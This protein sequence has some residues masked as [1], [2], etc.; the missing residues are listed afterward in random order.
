MTTPGKTI[1]LLTAALIAACGGSSVV[2]NSFDDGTGGST[3]S[4][5]SSSTSSSSSS[6][7]TG[8][9]NFGSCSEPGVC[10][11]HAPGCCGVCGKPTLGQ[12]DAINQSAT[13]AHYDATCDDPAGPCPGCASQPNPD[14]FAY[15]DL[16]KKQCVGAD[17][18]THPLNTCKQPSDC[19]LRYGL[20]CCECGS[21]GLGLTAV[22]VDYSPVAEL[23]CAGDVGCLECQ[24]TYPQDVMADCVGGKCV[25]AYLNP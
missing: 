24:P 4:S 7:S 23:V 21:E 5:S 3:T 8:G 17:F 19:T 6:S 2:D 20:S 9:P 11:L 25:V 15:C 18:A 10:V 12:L 13:Q 14:L 16:D 1:A 22:P